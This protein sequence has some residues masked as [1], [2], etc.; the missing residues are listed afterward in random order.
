M[1]YAEIPMLSA[2][3]V[4][5][6]ILLNFRFEMRKTRIQFRR[7]KEDREELTKTHNI[8]GEK[9]LD[10]QAKSFADI[11]FLFVCLKKMYKLFHKMQQYFPE[12][13]ELIAIENQYKKIF[14][15]IKSLRDDF[16]H[17]DERPEEGVKYLGSTFDTIYY[18]GDKEINIDSDL[19]KKIEDFFEETNIV[20]DKLLIEKRKQSGKPLLFRASIRIPK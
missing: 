11:N 4:E 1:K 13:Q 10:Q 16:E 5:T 3:D 2:T 8:D 18:F 20:Y 19:E 17:I 15:P 14:K 12:N 6:T 9:H 7:I